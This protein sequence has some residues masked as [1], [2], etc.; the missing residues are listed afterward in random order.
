MNRWQMLT[1]FLHRDWRDRSLRTIAVALF[2]AVTAVTAVSFFTDRLGRSMAQQASSLIAADLIANSSF[3]FPAAW[4]ELAEQHG[5]RHASSVSF[6]SVALSDDDESL[7]VSV[8]AVAGGYPLRGTLLL[9]KLGE[10]PRVA[11]G[12]PQ[13]GEVWVD[14]QLLS[15]LN[16]QV[17]DPLFMGASS[18]RVAAVVANEPDR[19][20]SLWQLSPRVMMNRADLAASELVGEGSRVRYALMFSGDE[21]ALGQFRSEAKALDQTDIRLQD[22]HQ[23]RP[24]MRTALDRL[25]QFLGLAAMISVVVAGSAV[26]ISA[27]SFARSQAKM[28]ALL[29]TFGASQKEVL[30]LIIWRLLALASVAALL[31]IAAAYGVQALVANALAGWFAVEMLPVAWSGALPGLVVAYCALL[32]FALPSV[33][34]V[35]KV[36]ITAILNDTVKSDAASLRRVIG[37]GIVATLGLL[38]WQAGHWLI[39]L[40]VFVGLLV[41]VAL[42]YLV[43]WA[44]ARSVREMPAG[45]T[46]GWRFGI[47]AWWRRRASVLVQVPAFG[48][49]ALALVLLTAVAT[50]LLSVWQQE[51]PEDAPNHFFINI[52]PD[53]M[54]AMEKAMDDMG[55]E[56][57]ALYPMIRGRM[58]GHNDKVLRAEDFDKGSEAYRHLRRD[59]NLS[60][61]DEADESN[62]LVAGEWWPEGQSDG[63]WSVST[64]VAEDFDIG[65]GDTLSFRV[66]GSVVSGKVANLR[67]VAWDSMKV[68]FFVLGNQAA[69]QNQPTTFITSMR[70]EES[71]VSQLPQLLREFPALTIFSVEAMLARVQGI[72][73]QGSMAVRLVLG[74]ALGAGVLVMVA[75]IQAGRSERAAE[76]ALLKTLGASRKQIRWSIASEFLS[77]GAVSGFLGALIASLISMG[78]AMWVFEFSYRINV[79]LCALCGLIGALLI[80]LSG[81]LTTREMLD[82]APAEVLRHN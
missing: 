45:L 9:G 54:P 57:V 77:L 72:L 8:K 38:M 36:P 55:V 35:Q 6:P 60:Y 42:L 68:N 12:L 25:A 66:A 18:L 64:D 44:V 52:Q 17:G 53:E 81:V 29:R 19:G 61:A 74:F 63:L 32:G 2:L 59:F 20:G 31:G 30:S 79:L 43:A 28:A 46:P 10:T 67:E 3:E 71:Q 69:L 27:R 48:A 21:P 56:D 76:V 16:I 4:L 23:A 15:R 1:F 82:S 5:L 39:G 22:V 78:V 65:V 80:G 34:G 73:Q 70:L 49:A 7:L 58:V 33:V 24:Q 75:A 14:E 50:D 62:T 41:L 40:L 51:L 26:A 13:P 11:E 37:V 47:S